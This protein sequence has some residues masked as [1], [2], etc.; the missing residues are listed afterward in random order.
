VE[1]LD[2]LVLTVTGLLTLHPFLSLEDDSLPAVRDSLFDTSPHLAIV[3]C[4]LKAW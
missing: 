2:I 3:S 4:N 1:I